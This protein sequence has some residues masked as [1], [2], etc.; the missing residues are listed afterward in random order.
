MRDDRTRLLDMIEAITNVG[1]YAVT[2]K[3]RFL[4][5]ELIRTYII[6]HLQVLGEAGTKLSAD[7]RS[8]YPDIPWPKVLGMRHVLVHDYFRVDYDIVWDVVE[9]ELPVL[10]IQLQRIVEEL[11]KK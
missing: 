5:D 6:H 8:R 11:K 1:R 3:E 7:L 10:K 4:E 9:K 2:G